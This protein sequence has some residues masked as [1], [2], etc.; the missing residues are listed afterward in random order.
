MPLIYKNMCN[1]LQVASCKICIA[2]KEMYLNCLNFPDKN[3][4]DFL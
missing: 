1:I 2:E 3:Y 4:N